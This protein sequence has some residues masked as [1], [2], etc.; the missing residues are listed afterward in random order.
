M[1][2]FWSIVVIN[3]FLMGLDS[4]TGKLT[5][6]RFVRT[7]GMILIVGS[8]LGFYASG[9]RGWRIVSSHLHR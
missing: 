1:N 4:F 8:L 5:Q 2:I 6:D 7:V 3:I 9:A